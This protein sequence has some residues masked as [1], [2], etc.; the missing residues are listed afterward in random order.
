[1]ATAA[2]GFGVYG[3]LVLRADKTPGIW[4]QAL[5]A[6]A[7]FGLGLAPY[8]LLLAQ[9]PHATATTNTIGSFMRGLV[10]AL[11][12][13]A[14]L[15]LGVAAGV[16]LLLYQFPVTVPVAAL[17][18]RRLG[19]SQPRE[20]WLLGLVAA[21]DVL[22]L[23]GATDPRTGGDYVWNLH[24]YLQ[25]YI[26]VTLLMAV[27]LVALWPRLTATRGRRLATLALAVALPVAAYA[28]APIA[29]RPL[30]AGLPGFRE[31][32]GR[33]NLRY[34][35][36]PWK[37]NE[38]G[39]RDLGE[40]LLAALPPHSRLFADYS[41]WAIINYLQR[42]EGARPDVQ[43]FNLTTPVPQL[44]LIQ[45]HADSD[46]L[47]LAD[48]NRYYDLAAIESAFEL[49]PAGPVYRLVPRAAGE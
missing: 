25:A 3:L 22:F 49:V 48:V 33:D 27:G 9:Q 12:N 19:R 46:A 23:L 10:T 5:A 37:H 42:V 20:A 40:S 28:V 11:F 47:Y 45:Q 31:L 16:A 39:A 2:L 44:T 18:A 43:L 41:L 17:G 14:Q 6:V 32:P 15:G 35:L 26:V 4:R 34:V 30:V 36:S 1:M 24:Y 38:T 13:P 29:A 21:G 8:V 7:C